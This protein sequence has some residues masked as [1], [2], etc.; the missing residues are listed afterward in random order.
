MHSSLCI[1]ILSLSMMPQFLVLSFWI[2]F[3]RGLFSQSREMN[4]DP[5]KMSSGNKYIRVVSLKAFITLTL[6]K[7]L[8]QHE[9]HRRRLNFMLSKNQFTTTAPH[10]DELHRI[11]QNFCGIRDWEKPSKNPCRH[12]ILRDQLIRSIC[13]KPAVLIIR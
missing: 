11:N 2:D 5:S 9:P 6:N 10:E 12:N 8:R 13:S 3:H 1:L 7:M 4:F